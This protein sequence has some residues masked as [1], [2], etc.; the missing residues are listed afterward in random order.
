L[1][2]ATERAAEARGSAVWAT[3]RLFS[4]GGNNPA[5]ADMIL[6]R[7]DPITQPRDEAGA[8]F[9]PRPPSNWKFREVDSHFCN[10]MVWK[11][12]QRRQNRSFAIGVA[13]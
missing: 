8:L 3:R 1:P 5:P 10:F 12:R 11:T 2:F 7:G 4:F 13:N 6:R 9:G